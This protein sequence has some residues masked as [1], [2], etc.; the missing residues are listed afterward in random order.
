MGAEGEVF[1]CIFPC[2]GPP[3]V[4]NGGN[5]SSGPRDEQPKPLIRSKH[6]AACEVEPAVSRVLVC[7]RHPPRARLYLDIVLA[8]R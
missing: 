6:K 8:R 2:A 4:R 3:H 7:P 1:C 5:A